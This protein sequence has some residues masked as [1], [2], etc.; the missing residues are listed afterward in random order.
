MMH[1][2][3]ILALILAGCA[4]PPSTFRQPVDIYNPPAEYAYY[5]DALYADFFWR[6]VTPRAR[7]ATRRR[8]RGDQSAEQHGDPELRSPALCPGRQGRDPSRALDL[9]GPVKPFQ[10]RTGP[11]C[12]CRPGGR[13]C[14]PVRPLLLFRGSGWQWKR[15]WIGPG[16]PPGP[17]GPDHVGSGTRLLRDHRGRVQRTVATKGAAPRSLTPRT[18]DYCSSNSL[19]INSLP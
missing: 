12:D 4:S 2:F 11:F 18:A 10:S 6:C 9:W 13:R 8:L 15:R 16:T 19:R 1:R 14:V 5:Y 3:L 17:A 7:G